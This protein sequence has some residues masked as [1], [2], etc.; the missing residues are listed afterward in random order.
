MLAKPAHCQSC[1]GWGWGCDGYV[2]ASGSG[3][4]GVLIV[5]ESAGE[6]EAADGM[7]LIGKAGHFFWSEMSRVGVE[8]EGFKCHNV[9]SCRP[10]DN[11]LA[12]MSYENEVIAHCSPLL[13]ATITGMQELCRQTGKTFTILTLGQIAFKRIMGFGPKH[14]ILK[15]DYLCYPF[16]SDRYGAWVIAVDHPSYLMRGNHHLTPVMQFGVQ[17]ALEIAEQGITL[18]QPRY[19]LDPPAAVFDKWVQDYLAVQSNLAFDIETPMK[20]G[21][22][23][24]V[25]AKEE[26]DDYTI[27]RCSFSY[28]PNEAITIPWKAE[29]M[30][31]LERLFLSEGPKIAHNANYDVPR[32]KRHMD[33]RGDLYDSMLAWHVLNSSMPKG[34]GFIA[35]F[36]CK[37]IL[38]WKHLSEADPATYNCIDSYVTLRCF[39]GIQRDLKNN[40]LW[41]VFEE[42]VVKLN[43]AFEYM[44]RIGVQL[45]L[46]GRKEAEVRL[47][48]MLTKTEADM[49]AVVPIGARRTKQKDG[50]KKTPKSTEGLVRRAFDVRVLTCNRCG[51]EEVSKAHIKAKKKGNP[52][53][54]ATLQEVQKQLERWAEPL[55]FKPSLVGMKNYQGVVKHRPVLSRRERKVTFDES[56]LLKLIR[57]YPQ[58]RLYPLVMDHRKVQKLLTTYIGVADELGMVRGGMQHDASGIIHPEFTHNPETLRSSCQHPN[59]QQLPRASDELSAIVRNLIVARPGHTFLA[60]DYSGIEAVLVG[61]FAM[62]PNYIRLAKMDVH[63]F[64]TAYAMNALDGRVSTA[65]LPNASWPNE[66]L[67]PHLA[68]IKGL[69]KKERNELYKHLVHGGNFMQGARGA[70]EKILTETGISYPVKTIQRVMD[71]YFELFPEI[72]RWHKSIMAQA[73][74]DGFVRNPFGYV[75]RFNKVYDYRKEGGKWV[76]EPGPQAN[77]V[78]ASGP[79]STAAGIIKEALLRL[80][81]NRFEEAGQYLRLLIHDELFLE[82]PEE[83]WERVHG[84]LKEEMERP[85]VKLPLPESYGMGPY[86][87]IDTEG[88]RGERWGSMRG[89]D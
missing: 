78:I 80:F 3:E 30:P 55:E 67:R 48:G 44:G 77:E 13:D 34:L 8:R 29:Y 60:N 86:L 52:C 16:W 69:F 24:E 64:Y 81:F 66:K 17:R 6:V 75:Q 5:A 18:H 63:S 35:P 42:H 46:E 19:Q 10:P 68:W 87:V 47:S 51:A 28:K 14:P 56:A 59:L 25:V 88:K 50:Y 12:G 9:L 7:P 2:P 4:N 22:N 85:I 79:Q 33:I 89:L 11:K 82:V 57:Q 65:D 20:K 72:R 27:L 23:E 1:L 32:I 38:M 41:E 21:K 53:E 39:E 36:Y 74:R 61:Y 62:A 70:Q 54:G 76:K 83:R 49:R 45:D 31:A 40:G 15:E 84:V 26:D 71:V 43:R 37:D 73:E 58:D